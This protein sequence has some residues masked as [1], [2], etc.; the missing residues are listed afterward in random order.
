MK[1][2]ELAS[3]QYI[4]R[5]VCIGP[6]KSVGLEYIEKKPRRVWR[7]EAYM[8]LKAVELK[9]ERHVYELWEYDRSPYYR[10]V[11]PVKTVLL[12]LL[13]VLLPLWIYVRR[14]ERARGRTYLNRSQWELRLS[15]LMTMI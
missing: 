9:D 10:Y 5:Y 14:L 13:C 4:Q 2:V 6:M 7:G 8:H 3:N 12:Y 15:M 1:D 11:P